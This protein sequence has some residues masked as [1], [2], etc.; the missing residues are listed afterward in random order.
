[1][2]HNIFRNALYVTIANLALVSPCLGESPIAESSKDLW[3]AVLQ[4]IHNGKSMAASKINTHFDVYDGEGK[5]LGAVDNMKQQTGWNKDEP[6]R[7]EVSS[8]TFG[9]PGMTMELSFGFE[10]H[11][12]EALDDLPKWSVKGPELLDAKPVIVILAEGKP[13][14]NQVKATVYIDAETKRPQKIDYIIPVNSAFG[15]GMCNVSL[16]YVA[17]GAGQWLPARVHIDQ[18]G[19]YMFWKRRLVINQEYIEWVKH[20]YAER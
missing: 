2:L 16:W 18:S 14:K 10:N 17:T 1:M 11:P 8:R 19:R 9:K 20:S 4:C 13:G 15:S 6:V 7:K 12:E 3:N 5:F